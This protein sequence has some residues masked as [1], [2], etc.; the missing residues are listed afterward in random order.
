[1]S[2]EEIQAFLEASEEIRFEGRN[3]KEV[4]CWVKQTLSRQQYHKQGK[5]QKGLL[6][7][8]LAKMTGLSRAQATRLI[9]RPRSLF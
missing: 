9:G 5:A 2:L 8:Y 6:R 1:M 3:R 4:Y 7:S